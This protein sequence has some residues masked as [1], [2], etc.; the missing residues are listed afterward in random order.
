HEK[1]HPVNRAQLIATAIR[2]VKNNPSF[3]DTLF[4]ISLYLNREKEFLPWVPL[5][6]ILAKI[7]EEYLN[8]NNEDLFEE[9]IRF[10]TNAIAETNFEGETLES[11]RIRKVFAPVLC[12]VKNKNCLSYAQKIFDQFLQNPSKNAFP[13]YGWDWVICTGLKDANDTVWEKFTSDEAPIKKSI[14]KIN[15][16]LIKCTNDNEKRDK[17]L[18]KIIHSNSTSRPYFVNRVFFFIKKKY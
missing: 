11:A 7:S 15:Y 18:M 16:K 2:N 14:Q 1:I 13:E 12:G 4:K 5:T 10:L 9:Y 17:Y 8:T 3:I 6:E